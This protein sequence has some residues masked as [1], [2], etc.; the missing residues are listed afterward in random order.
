MDLPATVLVV[1]EDLARVAFLSTR[2]GYEPDFRVAGFATSANEALTLARTLRPTVVVSDHD[3]P[4]LDGRL[5]LEGLRAAVPDAAI[6]L[7][8]AAWS[9]ARERTALLCGAD[10][11]LDKST[12]PSI[13][14]EALR[15]ARHRRADVAIA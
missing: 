4:D 2:L 7:Y 1:D 5:L 13:L 12:P 11:C 6:L 8:T 14:I 3:L 15:G 10:E 9:R